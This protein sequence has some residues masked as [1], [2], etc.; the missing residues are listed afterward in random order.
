MAEDA[1]RTRRRGANPNPSFDLD[2]LSLAEKVCLTLVAC[3]VE[4]GWAI[5]TEL[6]PDH[7]LGA[8]W[9]LSRP[10]TYR[11]IEQ[12][13]AKALVERASQR[14]GQGRERMVLHATAAAAPLVERWLDEPVAHLRDVRTELLLK[15]LLRRRKGLAL[16]PLLDAQRT[17]FAERFDALTA[18]GTDADLVDLW[19]RENARAVRRF[20]DAAI[21]QATGEPP[22]T[23]RTLLPLSARNQLRARVVSLTHGDVL[24]SVRAQLPDGQRVTA[25]VTKDSVDDLD[26]APGDTVL[27][28][29]KSTEV[30]LARV[31][32]PNPG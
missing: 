29:V 18:A 2:E 15:L 32:G 26:L 16:E 8:V 19:R 6:S 1:P 10:L 12:L 7:E 17:A 24:S 3:G 25:V 27:V 13:V 31:D 9:S 5:G 30:M 21:E 20:L 4:H 14:P 23:A 11:A 22:S 28:I